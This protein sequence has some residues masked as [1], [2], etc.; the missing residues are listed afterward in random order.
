MTDPNVCGSLL[1]VAF[2]FFVGFGIY[3]LCEAAAW[4]DEQAERMQGEKRP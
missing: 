1:V 2:L 4:G 3:A